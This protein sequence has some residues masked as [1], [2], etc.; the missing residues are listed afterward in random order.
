[1]VRVIDWS[2]LLALVMLPLA[3]R[4]SARPQADAPQRIALACLAAL[5]FAATSPA[6]KEI[7]IPATH[8]LYDFDTHRTLAELEKRQKRC[9]AWIIGGPKGTTFGMSY[10]H[11]RLL[12]HN[13]EIDANA[14]AAVVN[15]TVRLHFTKIH[16]TW[17]ARAGEQSYRSEL[18]DRLRDCIAE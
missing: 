1:M 18:I 11:F 17:N 14:D 16:V 15:G 6:R 7:A 3:E 12:K 2:D 4:L 13:E 9:H 10:E 8:P 5:A